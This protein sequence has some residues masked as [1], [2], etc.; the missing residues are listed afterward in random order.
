M[1][2]EELA[3]V[4][5]GDLG[6]GIPLRGDVS[7][8]DAS[9]LFYSAAARVALCSIWDGCDNDCG[10][11]TVEHFKNKLVESLY[12]YAASFAPFR[13]ALDL[14]NSDRLRDVA[15]EL[16]Q[17]Y[18]QTGNF[19]RCSSE[20]AHRIM[21]VPP[22]ASDCEGVSF[23]RG[24][25]PGQTVRMSGAGCYRAGGDGS[26]EDACR[27][28][29]FGEPVST[30]L[31]GAVA[32]TLA[33]KP[34][35]RVEYVEFLN[36]SIRPGR[37]S[38]WDAGYCDH[39]GLPSLAR[40]GQKGTETYVVYRCSGTE[41][42]EMAVLPAW[43][44][45]HPWGCGVT[46]DYTTKEYLRLAASA[47]SARGNL[48]KISYAVR[49]RLVHVKL[50]YLLPVAEENFFRLYSWPENFSG[51]GLPVRIGNENFDQQTD[52]I[53]TADLFRAFRRMMEHQGYTFIESR[54]A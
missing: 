26:V 8:L 7:A 42:V 45:D 41:D 53:M 6:Y 4:I 27:F 25:V 28:F 37:R 1:R 34:L 46:A 38:Y 48:P 12:A 29:G 43:R 2:A 10:Q 40:Y 44:C 35:P 15:E 39:D 52:R 17:T 3:R 32:S 11:Q 21:A 16:F 14:V 20:K 47:L 31:L 5:A 50:G 19:C 54:E 24:V 9:A 33:W 51:V 22:R 13:K 23:L 36:T 49:A 30:D 18:W